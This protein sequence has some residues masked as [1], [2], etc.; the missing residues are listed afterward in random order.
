M[1]QVFVSTVS[2]REPSMPLPSHVKINLKP[3]LPE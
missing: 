1:S 2:T 3:M